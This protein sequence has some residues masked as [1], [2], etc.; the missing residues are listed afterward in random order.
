[1]RRQ[2]AEPAIEYLFA[3]DER[4]PYPQGADFLLAFEKNRPSDFAF[5]RTSDQVDF[6]NSAFAGI[7]EWAAFPKHYRS[8]GLGHA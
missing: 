2:S 5:L 3:V 1:M 7:S 8:C 4:L 6:A